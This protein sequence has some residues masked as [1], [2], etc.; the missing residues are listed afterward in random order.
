MLGLCDT[1]LEAGRQTPGNHRLLRTNVL[2][3]EWLLAVTR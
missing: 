1:S 3:G 2:I